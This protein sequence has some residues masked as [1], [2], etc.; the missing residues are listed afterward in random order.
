MDHRLAEKAQAYGDKRNRTGD[1]LA[2]WTISLYRRDALVAFL[3]LLLQTACSPKPDNLYQSAQTSYR[4]G[5]VADAITQAEHG[6]SSLQ[7]Q[8]ESEWFWRF[9]LLSAEL[10]LVAGNTSRADSFL[11]TDLPSRLA[12][13][14]PRY[15]LLHAPTRYPVAGSINKRKVC[16]A[17][18]SPMHSPSPTLKLPSMAGYT[19]PP[20]KLT[21]EN[22]LPRIP[23]FCAPK[24]RRKPTVLTTNSPPPS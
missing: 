13:L 15:E 16:S 22:S 12:S 1:T 2:P 4:E 24:T 19:S 21:R 14:T 7:A 9:A 18:L 17:V 11:N 3:V 5:R 8:P 20:P 6:Y 23:P 10:N